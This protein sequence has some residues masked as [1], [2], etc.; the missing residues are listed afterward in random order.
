MCGCDVRLKCVD[1]IVGVERLMCGL[2]VSDVRVK[3]GCGCGC[4]ADKVW[5]WLYVL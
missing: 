2:D 4:C 3:C 5:R 1:V